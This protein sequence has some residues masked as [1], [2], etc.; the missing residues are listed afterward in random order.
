MPKRQAAAGEV[1][2]GVAAKYVHGEEA[3]AAVSDDWREGIREMVCVNLLPSTVWALV[4]TQNGFPTISNVELL[5]AEAKL[6]SLGEEKM[7]HRLSDTSHATAVEEGDRHFP[8]VQA[9][10]KASRLSSKEE[11]AAI[12]DE[13]VLPSPAQLQQSTRQG[14][15]S[16][17]RTVLT[18]GVAHDE[19]KSLLPMA[20]DT[21]NLKAITQEGLMIGMSAATIWNLRSG[22]VSNRRSPQDVRLHASLGNAGG[23]KFSRYSKAVASAKGIPSRL[24]FPV[25]VHHVQQMLALGDSCVH[26]GDRAR[27]GRHQE[28]Q[29]ASQPAS[30]LVCKRI[31][32]GT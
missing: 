18:W 12:F 21:L 25:G 23:G 14:Y 27:T 32:A 13:C 30:Q 16:S 3:A 6:W 20:Q 5:R 8:A 4:F 26:E 29:P 28:S 24:I 7:R 19:V 17:W 2:K 15:W 11:L 1:T 10:S 9:K 31:Q 22:W